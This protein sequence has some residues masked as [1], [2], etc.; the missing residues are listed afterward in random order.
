VRPQVITRLLE[1]GV[2]LSDDLFVHRKLTG[3]VA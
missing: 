3:K 1:E 2:R